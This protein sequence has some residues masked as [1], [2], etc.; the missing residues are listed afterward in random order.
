MENEQN[1]AVSIIIVNYNTCQ[2]TIACIQSV[3]EKTVTIPFEIIVVDN[4]SS[5]GSVDILRKTFPAIRII[6]SVTNLGFGKANNLGASFARGSFLLLLNS[7]TLLVNDAIGILF[8]YLSSP[9]NI[10]VGICGGN[11]YTKEMTPNHSYATFYPSLF[12]VIVYR[13]RLST[14]LKKSDVFNNTG[15]IKEVAII[16]GADLFIRK[17]L[18]DEMGGFDPFFFMYVEDGEL[19]YRVKK[20]GYQIVSVPNAKIIHYQGKSS[21]SAKKLIME[22]SSYVYYFNKHFK[23]STV[24]WYKI[25][26]L[27]F[28]GCKCLLSVLLGKKEI[29]SA[30]LSLIKYII[31]PEP[32]QPAGSENTEQ[33]AIETENPANIKNNHAKNQEITTKSI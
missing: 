17:S 9:E 27:F 12:N 20:A 11:L 4:A 32:A 23:P 21:T 14:I 1:I 7:D 6:P 18:F 16:I 26:E 2:L 28:A 13:S 30:N 29:C 3:L 15:S 8:N 19:S 25:I 10:K 22:V 5:D 31:S 24:K 33:K